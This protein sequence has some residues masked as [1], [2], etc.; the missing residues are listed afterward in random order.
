MAGRADPEWSTQLRP[1]DPILCC[2]RLSLPAVRL[3]PRHASRLL[4]D[5][6]ARPI[7][8]QRLGD[9]DRRQTRA[10]RRRH[11][12]ET[13]LANNQVGRKLP[14]RLALEMEDRFDRPRR[15]EIKVAILDAYMADRHARRHNVDDL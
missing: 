6:D 5:Q 13:I 14:C 11:R 7:T 4:L 1:M 8:V 3:R 15:I 2:A 9:E 12:I 10:F